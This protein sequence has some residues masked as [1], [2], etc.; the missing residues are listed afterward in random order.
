MNAQARLS[1]AL[2][3]CCSANNAKPKQLEACNCLLKKL[4]QAVTTAVNC[5]KQAV[6]KRISTV[7]SRNSIVPI[8]EE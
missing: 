5:N 3:L 8:S 6:A 1:N 2:Q 7:S 4:Q